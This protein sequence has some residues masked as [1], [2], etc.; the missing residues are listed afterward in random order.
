LG[1]SLD[2][3][4]SAGLALA[5][6]H[7]RDAESL[8][9]R[10][11][12]ALFECKRLRNG[13]QT[14]DPRTELARQQDLTL[15]S[16]LHSAV[17]QGEL[18]A[19]LQPKVSLAD[20]R[21]YGAECLIRWQ[22]PER[23]M[24]PPGDFIPFAERT[25]RIR[26]LTHWMLGEAL[27]LLAAPGQEALRLAV[28][29]S[30]HDLQDHTLVELL[31][32]RLPGSGVDPQRLTLEITESGLLEGSS[33]PIA[34]LQQLRALGLRLSIDDF[35]TGQSSLAYLQNLPVDELKIDRSFVREV[36][37]DPRREALLASIVQLGHSLGLQITAEG[38]EREAELKVLHRLGCDLV[39]GYWLAR[40]MDE[41]AFQAWCAA[42]ALEP[43]RP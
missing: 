20:G 6:A 21:L 38:V 42:R 1:Q 28:N 13:L 12:Q 37:G 14:Y 3:S 11:E 30:T 25:G 31:R 41:Q 19:Y 24:V 35:G 18:R 26:A 23:G 33:D 17:Q 27:R 5:P 22:H 9:R 10:A 16:Q 7:G 4:L 40:P 39:Q 29:I 43:H 8:L 15:A 2:L 34:L 36:D 32:E